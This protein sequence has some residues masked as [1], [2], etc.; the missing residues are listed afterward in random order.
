MSTVRPMSDHNSRHFVLRWSSLKGLTAII[1]FIVAAVLIEYLIILYAMK[2]GVKEESSVQWIFKFPGTDW[3]ATLTLSPFFHLVPAAAI[4][5]LTSSW[6]CLTKYVAMKPQKS[7]TEK[8]KLIKKAGRETRKESRIKSRFES[9][10][11]AFLSKIKLRLLKSRSIA[12]FSRKVSFAKATIKSA[13]LILLIFSALTLIV[14]ILAYPKVIYQTLS[15]FYIHNPSLLG[16]VKKVGTSTMG[17]FCSA[18]NN[19][20]LNFAP[21]FR[22]VIQ[23]VGSLIEPIV[24]LSPAGKYLVIQNVAVWVSASSVLLYGAIT[25]R[26]HRPRGVKKVWRP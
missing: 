11:K 21:A 19:A 25:K 5:A 6:I 18:F 7:S 13:F 23:S 20:I 9:S 8:G 10:A 24:K 4:I 3:T 2:L 1:L 17:W 14:S 26:R 15:N 12:L 22:N 16:F